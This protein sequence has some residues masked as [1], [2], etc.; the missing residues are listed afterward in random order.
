[1]V[2]FNKADTIWPGCKT[3]LAWV[4]CWMPVYLFANAP[5]AEFTASTTN[6]CTGQINFS[7][8]SDYSPTSWFWDFGDGSTSTLQNPSHFYQ[9]YGVF[10]VSLTVGNTAGTDT[11]I[12]AGYITIEKPKPTN[13][14]PTTID[15]SMNFGITNFKFNTI[16]QNSIGSSAGYQNFTCTKTTVYAS[17]IYAISAVTNTPAE[18]NVRAWLDY[19]D[20]G[21]FDPVSELIFSADNVLN[22]SGTVLIPTTAIKNTPLRL[23]ISADYFLVN[24]P[25]PCANL[26]YGQAE[27]YTVIILSPDFPPVAAL[28][29]E[30][31][32]TCDGVV[33]FKDSSSN[34][35]DSWSWN[36]GDG[37]TSNLQNPVHTYAASGTYTVSLTV[38]NSFGSNSVTRSNFITVDLNGLVKPAT[39]SP[40]TMNYCCGYG[41]RQF[42][43]KTINNTTADAS[44]GYKDFSCRF[45]TT[46]REGEYVPISIKTNPGEPQD[47]RV[48]IDYNNDGAFSASELVFEKLNAYDPL[49]LVLIKGGA[50]LNTPLR[51]RVSS[52]FAGSGHNA[53]SNHTFGQVEDYGLKIEPVISAP[54]V[55]F[56]ADK[57]FSCDGKINFKD[58]SSNIPNNWFWEFGDGNTS[59]IQNPSHTYQKSGFYTVKLSAG[60]QFGT[61]S[62][63]YEG[64]IRIEKG[65]CDTVLMPTFGQAPIIR[66]CTGTLLDDGGLGDYSAIS[67]GMVVIAPLG[68]IQLTLKFSYFFFNP[69]SDYLLIYDGTSTDSPL[70]G[71]FT[72]SDL[73]MGGTVYSSSGAL[74]IVQQTDNWLP[75]SGF[76]ATWDCISSVEELKAE[77][78]NFTIFPNPTSG[79]TAIKLSGPWAITQPDV[80]VKNLLGEV[81]LKQSAK[82]DGGP[83]A[84][85]LTGLPKGAYIVSVSSGFSRKSKKLI[86]N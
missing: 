63:F 53:C 48:W 50:A 15:G 45:S 84:L 52:D 54:V 46:V 17:Q 13:C 57:N 43:F 62:K 70:I 11:K 58:I 76:F 29:A 47:T 16:N 77:P 28:G 78:E 6:S 35:P 18:H 86:I 10:S 42:S 51:I 79:N 9:S 34:I 30:N 32:K 44:E 21:I 83:V 7:D 61:N 22:S 69:W 73:P 65:G 8:L 27:D 68:T 60:N 74:T 85:G 67:D 12:K 66:S 1:M 82:G 3:I 39:C 4:L 5:V 33:A 2:H 49:G 36:F 24:P 81:V 40:I 41:I 19:N 20:D 72:G 25:G 14:T 80:E 55:D 71:A 38:S 26:Q 56:I 59:T 64:F 75:M 37:N 23:R 31:T